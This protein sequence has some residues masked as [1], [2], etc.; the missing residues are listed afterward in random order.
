MIGKLYQKTSKCEYCEELFWVISDR[1]FFIFSEFLNSKLFYH[2]YKCLMKKYA[3][4]K[5]EV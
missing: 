2:E 1:P 5:E 3:G 4:K